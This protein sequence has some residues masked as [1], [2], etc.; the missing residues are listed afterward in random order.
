[1]AHVSVA[2]RQLSWSLDL[3]SFISVIEFT[4]HIKSLS[5]VVLTLNIYNLIFVPQILHAVLVFLVFVLFV[6][7]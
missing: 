1:M 3:H 6:G 2:L 4:L 5:I 7:C